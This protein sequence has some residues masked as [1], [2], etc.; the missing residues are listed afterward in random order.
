MN[1][2]T[3]A[4]TA[5]LWLLVLTAKLTAQDA[6]IFPPNPEKRKL[7]AV[8]IEEHLKVDGR[9]DEAIWQSA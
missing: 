6:T 7:E 3:H 2:L 9:M 1:K 8:K 5:G 4:F